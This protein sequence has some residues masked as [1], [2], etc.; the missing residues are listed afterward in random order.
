VLRG[1]SDF[2]LCRFSGRLF[3][4]KYMTLTKLAF[5]I[6]N[7]TINSNATFY[8]YIRSSTLMP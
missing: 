3:C 8:I 2:V 5:S 4:G 6:D 1:I 7:L